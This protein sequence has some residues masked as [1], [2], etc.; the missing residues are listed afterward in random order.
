[1]KAKHNLHFRLQAA[2][3]T[4]PSRVCFR[5]F[6][7]FSL[8]LAAMPSSMAAQTSDSPSRLLS[9]DC[10]DPGSMYSDVTLHSFYIPMRDGVKIAID[11]AVP[12]GLA[13]DAKVPALLQMTRYWRSRQGEG[14]SDFQ[15]Y[16]GSRGYAT[17]VGDSRGTGASFGIWRY[18]RNSEE[19]RDFYDIVSWIVAQ[20]WSDGRVAAIGL[21]YSANTADWV[22]AMGHPAVKAIVTRFPDFDPYSDLYFPGG[23]FHT[24]FGKAWSEKVKSLDLDVS[25]GEPPAG[26]KPTDEDKDQAL[27]HAAIQQRIDIPPVYEGLRQI[28]FRDDIPST[29]GVSMMD[30]S[31]SNHLKELQSSSVAI[32]TWGSWFDSGMANGI[33]E[34]FSTVSNPQLAIIGPWSH[35]ARHEADPYH[36]WGTPPTP[37][38]AS[39]RLNDLCFVQKTLATGNQPKREKLLA[40]YTLGEDKWK[41]T[42][43]WPVPSA[44]NKPWYFASKGTL[45]KHSPRESAGRDNYEV[46]FDATTG[47]DNRWHTQIGGHPVSYPDRAQQDRQLLT[48]TSMPLKDDLEITGN[49]VA[50]LFVSTTTTDC[51]IFVYLEDVLPNGKVLYLTEGELRALHRGETSR[52]L[53]YRIF[54]P[55]HSFLRKD[56]LPIL[57]GKLM[58]LKI[59]LLPIS[60]RLK[61]GHRLR[62]A[63][64]GADK[65]TFARI[66]EAGRSTI[67]IE[68]SIRH[69]SL[70]EI[71]SVPIH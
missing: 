23:I 5:L 66:P 64:A 52:T 21:S 56:A 45:V 33:I 26:V 53:P 14:P 3:A 43:R 18:H 29:W 57:P 46:N 61:R 16:W 1:M 70:I 55:H 38:A 62:V 15:R 60:V 7:I 19:R 59:G 32:D 10:P 68:R 42:D 27:L 49:P 13:Q 24:S 28:V 51:A 40:Y 69:G 30:W 12:K 71:P 41:K 25:N 47:V 35:G 8:L 4:T 20:P 58:S 9:L 34:Q 36:G 22:A 2:L 11:L 17:I 6:F 67:S 39:Q 48:Y 65:D 63:I 54:G 50:T 44:V 37:D 31:I